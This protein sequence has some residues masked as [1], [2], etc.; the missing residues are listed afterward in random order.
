MS[1]AN[2]IESSV[3]TE[4]A[5]QE[6]PNV[7]DRQVQEIYASIVA[8]RHRLERLNEEM[9]FVRNLQITS[10]LTTALKTTTPPEC[11]EELVFTGGSEPIMRSAENKL[12]KFMQQSV[13]IEPVALS[14]ICKQLASTG[15]EEL[16]SHRFL[17]KYA[18]ERLDQQGKTRAWYANFLLNDA[19]RKVQVLTTEE[20]AQIKETFTQ[21]HIPFSGDF[22]RRCQRI[23]P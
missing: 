11:I 8:N 15:K 21:Y 16:P 3:M 5:L 6:A 9:G 17:L 10:L 13:D 2:R 7:R 12:S 14:Q 4:P 19:A 18:L 22:V 1:A 20:W 23:K